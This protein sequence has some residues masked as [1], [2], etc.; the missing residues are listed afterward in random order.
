M[1]VFL[2]WSK[3]KKNKVVFEVLSPSWERVFVL[4]AA[5]LFCACFVHPFFPSLEL[6]RVTVFVI[7]KGFCCS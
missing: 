2:S 1:Q 7:F 3:R 6:Y 5:G 4:Q